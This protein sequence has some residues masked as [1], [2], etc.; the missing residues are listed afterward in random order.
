MNS[1]IMMM[2]YASLMLLRDIAKLISVPLMLPNLTVRNST[3]CV[4]VIFA[5]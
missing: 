5:I 4:G 2:V 1:Q 3:L